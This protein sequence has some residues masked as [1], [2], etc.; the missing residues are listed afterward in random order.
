MQF[1][2][3][4]VVLLKYCRNLSAFHHDKKVGDLNYRLNLSPYMKTHPVF[5]LDRLKQFVDSQEITYS[6]RSNVSD[7]VGDHASNDSTV[8]RMASREHSRL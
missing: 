3:K 2:Y 7:H 8:E 6:H 4:I 1:Q 5:Y